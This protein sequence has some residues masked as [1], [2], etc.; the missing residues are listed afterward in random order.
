MDTE[1][2]TWTCVCGKTI[3]CE[4]ANRLAAEYRA[5]ES[6]WRPLDPMDG[7]DHVMV[8]SYGCARERSKGKPFLCNNEIYERSL[9]DFRLC[10]KPA[11][12]SIA[13]SP[14]TVC[15]DCLLRFLRTKDSNGD[16]FFSDAELEIRLL[17]GGHPGDI[18]APGGKGQERDGH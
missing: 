5:G 13:R 1:S 6:G 12:F 17:K 16:R 14:Y 10:R 8:C 4:G 7:S 2:F 3:T 18:F 9:D 15:G 11:E